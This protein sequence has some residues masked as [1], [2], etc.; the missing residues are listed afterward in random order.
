MANILI[1][2]DVHARSFWKQAIEEKL[3]EVDKVILLGDYVDP[4]PEEGFTRKNAIATLEEVIKLKQE[5]PDKVILLLG[6]HCMQYVNRRFDTRSRFD[7]SNAY[8]IMEIFKSHRSL[9]KLAHEE[10]IANKRFLFTHAGL[11]MTWYE[12]FKDLIGDLTVDNLNHLTETPGGVDALADYSSYRGMF[13]STTGSIVW[14]DIRE[15][16]GYE[17][18]A[19]ADG[20]DFQIFGHTQLHENPIVT[21]TW[22]C[23]DCRRA[24]ILDENGNLKELD[25]SD[26]HKA[27]MK[28]DE[29]D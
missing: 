13:G 2:P 11:M 10:T 21:D 20:F 28:T 29:K 17:E 19:N 14:S 25:G 7:S 1:I 12:R 4:Y 5:N 26:I 18:D 9:F 27:E 6:N 23:L 3:N 22:A 15:K 24:F 8:K 16:F